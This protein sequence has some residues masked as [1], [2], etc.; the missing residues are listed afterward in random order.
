[1]K[2]HEMI[3]IIENGG[4]VGFDPNVPEE[5]GWVCQ[6]L[7]QLDDTLTAKARWYPEGEF[8]RV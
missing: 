8:N 7:E 1:M 2:L 3:K 6:T 4:Q 5:D